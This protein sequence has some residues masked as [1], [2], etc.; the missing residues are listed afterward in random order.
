MKAPEP[1]KVGLKQGTEVPL[2][3]AMNLEAGASKQGT[4]VPFI[5]A[6]DV[7]GDDGSTVIAK[8]AIGYGQV[9][10]SRSEG[11]LSAMMNQPA[12]LDVRLDY[13]VAK[14]GQ[15]VKLEAEPGKGDDAY[16]FTRAN[17][18][19]I[20][21]SGTA[22]QAW[23]NPDKQKAMT[24]LLQLIERSKQ[25]DLANDPQTAEVLDRLS[26]DLNLSYG[27]LDPKSKERVSS[28]LGSVGNGEVTLEGLARAALPEVNALLELTRVTGFIGKQIG[29][30]LKGRTIRAYVGTPVTAYVRTDQTITVMPE[31]VK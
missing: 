7:K 25:S 16:E 10:W 3:L 19:K 23:S 18:G 26:K 17:T 12:R 5:V 15:K 27:R 14:D 9:V 29:G 31:D 21:E 20:G 6:D 2:I 11:T 28:L 8:G 24:T 13:V 4:V 30:T 22:E 1:K